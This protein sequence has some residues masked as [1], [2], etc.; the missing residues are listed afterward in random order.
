M[1]GKFHL[2]RKMTSVDPIAFKRVNA[3]IRGFEILE[4]LADKKESLGISEIAGRLKM[5]KGTVFGMVHTL[6]ELRVLEKRSGKYIFGPK[7]Y[8]LGKAAEKGANLVQAARPY[9]EKISR[10]TN[11]STFL[12]M[13]LGLEMV[14]LDKVDTG[15]KFKISLDIGT[16]IPLFPGAHGKALLSQL[17]DDELNDLL[18]MARLR[19]IGSRS[20]ITMAEYRRKIRVARSQ[21]VAFDR[22]EFVEG[23]RGLAVPLETGREPQTVI[24]A[25]G[26]NGQLKDPVMKSCSKV[27]KEVA[28]EIR[29]EFSA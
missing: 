1:F 25:M 2:M 14:I 11:L 29:R 22:E 23:I 28:E 21:G 15:S 3:L 6:A 4:L 7:L 20:R 8:M 12:G 19:D 26:V 24:W 5:H 13:R 18:S 16:Q 17:A 27:L 9:L 10:L